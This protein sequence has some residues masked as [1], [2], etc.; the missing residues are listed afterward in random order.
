MNPSI[1]DRWPLLLHDQARLEY[2][3]LLWK[4]PSAKKRLLKH[5]N[6]ERH[7]YASR[8]SKTYRPWVEKVL[9]AGPETDDALDEELSRH[10]LSLRVV[11]REIP[12]VFGSFY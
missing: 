1:H 7:P 11:V 2:G 12:P 5:W 8:F 4:R 3:R 9:E 10:G 6:D